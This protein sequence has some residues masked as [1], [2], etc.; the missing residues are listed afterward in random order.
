VKIIIDTAARN[1]TTVDG[2]SEQTYDLYSRAAF[3]TISLQWVRMGWSLRYYHNFQWMGRPAL[4]LPEDLVRLQEAVYSIRPDVIVETG[5][6]QG[7]SLMFHATLCQALGKGR[8]IGIDNQIGVELREAIGGHLLGQR[9]SLVE[10]DSTSREVVSAVARMIRPGE[11]VLVILDSCHTKDHVTRE[12]E[13]YSRFVTRGSYIIAADG[14]MRDLS[15]VP[16]GQAE[17]AWDNPLTAA[18][19]FAARHPEFRQQSDEAASVTYW[20]GAWLERVA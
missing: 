6:F 18:S 4:Q 20:P 2:E 9:I 15:D 17:W 5:I 8:V 12:L 14:I 3:E 19:E 11:T 10:G 1:L 16:G 7:G 13:C